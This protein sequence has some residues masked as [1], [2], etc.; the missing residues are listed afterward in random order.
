MPHTEMRDLASMFPKHKGCKTQQGAR[1]RIA[2]CVALLGED[3]AKFGFVYITTQRTGG[4]WL[5]I[6]ILGDFNRH[7]AL[8]LAN[9]GVCVT[10]V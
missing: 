1:N 9:R 7:L 8:F 5:A 2:K 3:A 6:A 10:N 4:E